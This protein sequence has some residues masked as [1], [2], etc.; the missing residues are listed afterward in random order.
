M[1]QVSS[2]T[3]YNVNI[4]SYNPSPRYS[5]SPPQSPRKTLPREPKP[6]TEAS[7][8]SRPRTQ[9]TQNP[10][11]EQRQSPHR[12]P[13]IFSKASKEPRR[14]DEDIPTQHN[15][16]QATPSIA[17]AAPKPFKSILPPNRFNSSKGVTRKM[18]LAERT[19]SIT[20]RLSFFSE[21]EENDEL[22][23]L[24]NLDMRI[25]RFASRSIGSGQSKPQVAKLSD[26]HVVSPQSETVSPYDLDAVLRSGSTK[27]EF[28]P[29]SFP[30]ASNSPISGSTEY[31]EAL[32]A[33]N[34]Q[35]GQIDHSH[36][37]LQD[38]RAKEIRFASTALGGPFKPILKDLPLRHFRSQESIPKEEGNGSSVGASALPKMSHTVR[39]TPNSTDGSTYSSETK[40]ADIAIK[41][42]SFSPPDLTQTTSAYKPGDATSSEY[43]K[44]QFDS[45]S[46]PSESSDAPLPAHA[47]PLKPIN[48]APKTPPCEDSR[49]ST[50]LEKLTSACVTGPEVDFYP[51]I[52]SPSPSTRSYADTLR[53]H[54][55]TTRSHADTPSE[56]NETAL[57]ARGAP[58]SRSKAAGYNLQLHHPSASTSALTNGRSAIGSSD[59]SDDH[60]PPAEREPK[61]P[62][63]KVFG[64]V[65][66]G[67]S[68]KSPG[69]SAKGSGHRKSKS[70]K[71]DM[72]V[73][74]PDAERDRTKRW[75]DLVRRESFGQTADSKRFAGLGKEG[76]WPPRKNILRT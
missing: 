38:I 20:R 42:S 54:A 34:Q 26:D 53:S 13:S 52:P 39:D 22:G 33:A 1:K 2:D 67:G 29:L 18:S 28:S 36:L 74:S 5:L 46:P 73:F 55:D 4:P 75:R 47:T 30:S 49:A 44:S 68:S 60:N 14:P 15:S 11:A 48:A 19:R 72:S 31:H 66:F 35:Y 24:P 21:S 27:T 43:S 59:H 69:E 6:S 3:P 37:P 16:S 63:K 45:L 50:P 25:D 57:H 70:E 40:P 58:V 32:R 8:S 61:S 64:N 17:A 65:G 41:M 9:E 56:V 23:P 51:Y 71:L 10:P 12:S 76:L 7:Q 62:W